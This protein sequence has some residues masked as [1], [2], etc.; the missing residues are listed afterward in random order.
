MKSRVEI[1]LLACFGALT[2]ISLVTL[3]LYF[4]FGGKR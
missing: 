2:A 1:S 3:I 4:A